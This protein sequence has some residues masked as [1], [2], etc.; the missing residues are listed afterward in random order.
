MPQD[1]RVN[2][3]EI[4]SKISPDFDLS[5]LIYFILIQIKMFPYE[6]CQVRSCP[7]T[8]DWENIN[9]T[10]QP[11]CI[12]YGK[13]LLDLEIY[14]S[15]KEKKIFSSTQEIPEASFP[16]Q[17]SRSLKGCCD[18]Q[19]WTEWNVHLSQGLLLQTK[20]FEMYILLSFEQRELF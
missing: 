8:K 10:V 7:L 2:S 14:A 9:H 15:S 18:C 1:L 5:T 16:S 12:R 17:H 20:G 13:N 11:G 19:S 6:R 4:S 3:L